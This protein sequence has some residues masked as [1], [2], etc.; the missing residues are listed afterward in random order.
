M[1][2]MDFGNEAGRCENLILPK[3]QVC[4]GQVLAPL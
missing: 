2:E 4:P 1:K 3:A